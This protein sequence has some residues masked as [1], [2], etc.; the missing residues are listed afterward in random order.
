MLTADHVN[1]EH[2]NPIVA[3]APIAVQRRYLRHQLDTGDPFLAPVFDG[4][5]PQGSV[6]IIGPD[7]EPEMVNPVLFARHGWVKDFA[8]VEQAGGRSHIEMLATNRADFQAYVGDRAVNR[9]VIKFRMI[10]AI[11]DTG[12]EAVGFTDGRDTYGTQP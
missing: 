8:A 3:Q 4:P 10:R 7:G 9:A 2:W 12:L 1:P 5:G 6:Q 11:G